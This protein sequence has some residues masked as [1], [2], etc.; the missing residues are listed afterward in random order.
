V[1]VALLDATD[2]VPPN[3]LLDALE[4]AGRALWAQLGRPEERDPT[5]GDDDG[6]R[7]VRLDGLQSRLARGVAASICA[8]TGST[9]ART[10]AESLDPAAWWMFGAEGRDRFDHTTPAHLPGSILLESAGL[11][12]LRRGR[13]RVTMDAGTLGYLSLAA[14][15]HADALSVTLSANGTDL[16]VDPGSGTYFGRALPIRNAF[17][18][19]GFHATVLLDGKDQSSP[20]GAFLWTRHANSRFHR[21]DLFRALATAEHDGYLGDAL[22]V[23]HRRAVLVLESGDVVVYDRLEGEGVHTASLRWPLHPSLRAKVAGPDEVHARAHAATGL[24]LKTAATAAGE[25]SVARGKR[26]PLEG[27]SSPRL[28]ELVPAPLVKWDVVFDGRLDGVTLLAPVAMEA[29]WPEVELHLEGDREV[30][31]IEVMTLAGRETIRMVLD[32]SSSPY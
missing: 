28:D 29:E 25:L 7:A 9:F 11:A 6:G 8:R 27:W 15:G 1:A 2:F 5:Y 4:R 21:V 26:E 16:V 20:G 19:T 22:P 18:G 3:E 30:V 10:V 31:R 23:R 14:H 17:R 24:L 12:I 13:S 32:D